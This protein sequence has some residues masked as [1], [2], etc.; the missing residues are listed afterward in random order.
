MVGLKSLQGY[1]GFYMGI[2]D[3]IVDFRRDPL[4]VVAISDV[5]PGETIITMKGWYIKV[6]WKDSSSD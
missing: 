2:L 6:F 4:V 1:Q 5:P 3:E